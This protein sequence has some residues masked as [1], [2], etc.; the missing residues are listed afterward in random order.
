MDFFVAVL[1]IIIGLSVCFSGLY[2]FFFMLPIWGFIAGFLLGAAGVTAIFGDGFLA[3]GTGFLV[4]IVVGIGAAILSYLYWYV[5]VLLAAGVAGW[6][7]GL[8]LMGTLGVDSNWLLFLVGAAFAAVFVLGALVINYP[9]YLVI[10]NT[11]LGGAVV[12]IGGLLI[13]LGKVERIELGSGVVW[14]RIQ[15]NWWLW[16]VWLGL[17]LAGVIGQLQKMSEVTLPEEKWTKVQVQTV[18]PMTA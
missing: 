10:A 2:F 1:G 9:I 13:L 11:A 12:A 7:I 18:G 4:G 15:D 3:T 6:A 16:L 5:A 8:A 14:E 17:S